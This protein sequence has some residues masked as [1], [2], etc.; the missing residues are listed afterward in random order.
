MSP[1]PL[2]SNLELTDLLALTKREFLFSTHCHALGTVQSFNAATQLATISVNY[3]RVYAGQAL[4]YPPIVECPIVILGGGTGSLEFPIQQGDTGLLCFNDRDMDEWLITGQT[5]KEPASSRLH[6][7]SD[8]IFLCGVR[9]QTKA[10]SDYSASYARF[11]LGATKVELSDTIK[12]ANQVTDLKAVLNG[13]LDLL[14]TLAGDITSAGM[15]TAT[16]TAFVASVTA[17]KTTVAG[18]LT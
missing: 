11:R 15:P 3:K 14:S 7:F 18:L 5:G 8:A 13:M 9:P 12:I 1:A 4:D 17:Y 6:S 2:P 10:I 16:Q